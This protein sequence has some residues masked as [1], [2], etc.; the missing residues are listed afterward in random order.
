[1]TPFYIFSTQRSGSTVLIKTIDQHPE[2]LCAGELFFPGHG[3]HHQEFQYPFFGKQLITNKKILT[4]LNKPLLGSHVHKFLDTFYRCAGNDSTNAV[5]FKLMLGQYNLSPAAFQ[6]SLQDKKCI[7]LIRKN[8]L[9]MALSKIQ[10]S[11]SK[12]YHVPAQEDEGKKLPENIQKKLRISPPHL[13]SMMQKLEADNNQ[14]LNVAKD[15]L[16]IE[17]EEFSNWSKVI[18]KITVYLQVKQMDLSP[19]LRKIG[20]SSLENTIENFDEVRNYIL[21]SRFSYLIEG[22]F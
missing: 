18:D 17:Y 7:L 8:L 21:S 9:R 2:I 12:V 11:A 4:V 5:G 1:M 14:L 16:K 10:A 15:A 3:I 20:D 6:K 22:N 13:Y 19:A